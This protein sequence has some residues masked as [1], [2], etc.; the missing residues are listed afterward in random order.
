MIKLILPILLFSQCCLSQSLTDYNIYSS[1]INTRLE[2]WKISKE[3]RNE[4]VI[5]DY[6]TA[7]SQRIDF[8]DYAEIFA[9]DD[10]NLLYV[11]FNYKDSLIKLSSSTEFR[12]LIKRFVTNYN[13]PRILTPENF[14]LLCNIKIVSSDKIQNLFSI[15][16]PKAVD[17]A[18]K[19]FYKQYPNSLGYFELSN[20][21]YSDNYALLYIVHR[22][23][24]LI[25]DGQLIILKKINNNWKF[26]ESL[27]LWME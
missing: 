15:R 21:E 6:L 10:K 17:K 11:T 12:D 2:N 1:I 19:K 20:I 16:K 5:T 13:K 9:G 22:A 24:P 3:S 18:W 25:G 7:F 4:I 8:Q 23:K 26:Y 27:N 14:N